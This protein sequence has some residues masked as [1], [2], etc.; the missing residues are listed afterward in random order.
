MKKEFYGFYEP[1]LIE[2]DKSWNNGFFVFDANTLLN[3]YRYSDSTRKDFLM[4]ITKLKEKLFMPYQVGYEYH[5]NRHNVIE[6]IDKSY[7]TLLTSIKETCDKTITNTINQYLRHPSIHAENLKKTLDEF[8]KKIDS[9]LEKQKNNH[10][11]FKSKDEILLQL[12]ELFENKV[13]KQFTSN[14]LKKIYIEGKDRNE[15]QI[16]PGFKDL[17]TKRK[18]GDQHIYGD[19]IIWKEIIDLTKKEKKEIIFITDD[20]KEDWWT[21]EN[22][23]TIRP[24]E[25]LI[26]EFY[27]LTGVRIL[28]YNA[29][30]FLHYAKERKLVSKIKEES[31]SE[32][33]E[34]RKS[35]E[36]LIKISD[37]LTSTQWHNTFGAKISDLLKNTNDLTHW[38][39]PTGSTIAELLKTTNNLTNWY[40]P[41]GATIAESLINKNDLNNLFKTTNLEA[42]SQ[43]KNDNNT[44][45]I[46][47]NKEETKLKAKDEIL[48]DDNVVIPKP[49]EKTKDLKKKLVIK[50]NSNNKL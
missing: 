1:S 47:I 32:V 49:I 12:T 14:E 41:T 7:D 2:I 25:E 37:Y 24:R 11:D 17:E 30:N 36:N 48:K 19:L 23:K 35:D 28:I 5:S 6:S 50:K 26:K 16:P 22:G 45:N 39:N 8:Q 4:V 9:E 20:R 33:K 21:I 40:N 29:D 15:Q 10:P 18:K 38:S 43:L 13:G 27:D 3:L 46:I 42:S 44:N 34:V 31:I